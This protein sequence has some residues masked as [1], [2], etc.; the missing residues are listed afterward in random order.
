MGEL[1]QGKGDEAKRLERAGKLIETLR[2][3]QARTF[4]ILEEL[5]LVVSGERTV[6]QRARWL[7]DTFGALWTERYKSKYHWS[8]AK[9]AVSAR[10]L[11]QEYPSDADLAGRVERYLA[12]RQAFYAKE[13]HPFSLFAMHVNRFAV[14]PDV[15]ELEG[16]SAPVGC[17]HSPACAN[18]SA[19]T[20]RI[21]RE[22]R[23]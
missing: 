12:D 5:Q 18:D 10:K 14:A 1:K 17:L 2:E 21:M 6:A 23:S 4:E 16:A 20:T 9:D 15:L 11:A 3:A 13:S 7:M 8:G 19:H 22:L